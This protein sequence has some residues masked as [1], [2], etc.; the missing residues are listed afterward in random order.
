MKLATDSVLNFWPNLAT[1]SNTNTTTNLICLNCGW[2]KAVD[3]V[4]WPK[5]IHQL[6]CRQHSRRLKHSV[7]ACLCFCSVWSYSFLF[8]NVRSLL[9]H[10]YLYLLSYPFTSFVVAYFQ[11]IQIFV[12]TSEQK[13]FSRSINLIFSIYK[14]LSCACVARTLL[15]VVLSIKAPSHC[16]CF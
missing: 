1:I 2:R 15:I 7:F 6:S 4:N 9:F 12:I 11:F 5:N 8:L 14:L 10:L 13:S 16:L 3:R